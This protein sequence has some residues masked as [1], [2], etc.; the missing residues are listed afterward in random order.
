MHRRYPSIANIATTYK[1]HSLEK[2]T[3]SLWCRANDSC[4]IS[5]QKYWSK[6]DRDY[7]NKNQTRCMI[8]DYGTISLE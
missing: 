5:A 3:A 7:H 2:T 6:S 4:F 1:I 8:L